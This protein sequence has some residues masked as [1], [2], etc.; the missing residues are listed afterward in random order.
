MEVEEMFSLF[1]PPHSGLSFLSTCILEGAGT[2][3]PRT[4]V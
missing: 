3:L 4:P 2:H 1:Y